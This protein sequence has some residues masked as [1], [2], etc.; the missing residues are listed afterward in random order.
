M[1]WPAN[2]TDDVESYRVLFGPDENTHTSSVL[3]VVR[4]SDNTD[5]ILSVV[6]D[7]SNDLNLQGTEGGCFRVTAVRGPEESE[8]SEP[9]CF[10]LG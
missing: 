10:N 6:Y 3:S 2:L 4:A 9:I 8:P 7:L 1:S 5:G